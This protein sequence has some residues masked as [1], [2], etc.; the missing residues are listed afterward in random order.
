MIENETLETLP[1]ETAEELTMA[2][3]AR[4]L[5]MPRGTIWD[6]AGPTLTARQACLYLPRLREA[7]RAGGP[8]GFSVYLAE[9]MLPGDWA[10]VKRAVEE[11][12]AY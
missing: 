8:V 4:A 3:A 5:E 2:A 11:G 1:R 7:R 12:L 6:L 10:G 9:S